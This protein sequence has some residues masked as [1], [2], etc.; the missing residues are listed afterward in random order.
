[1]VKSYFQ[2]KIYAH[3][4]TMVKND[5]KEQVYGVF[6]NTCGESPRD[7]RLCFDL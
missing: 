4:F 6:Q 2:E 3:S 5:T 7:N 1:M